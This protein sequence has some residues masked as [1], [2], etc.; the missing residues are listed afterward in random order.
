[1]GRGGRGMPEGEERNDPS[2]EALFREAEESVDRIQKERQ[3][4]E[5]GAGA[6]DAEA[7][8]LQAELDRV[9][10]MLEKVEAVRKETNEKWLK[11]TAE[12]QKAEAEKKDFS[13]KALRALAELENF[14]KRVAKER[15]D[16]QKYAPEGLAKEILGVADNLE[17]A[18]D[19]AQAQP[20]QDP[21]LVK[22]AEGVRM[23]RTQLMQAL[24]RFEIKPFES[25]GQPFDPAKHQAMSHLDTRDAPPGTVMSEMQKGY[26]LHDRLLRPAFVV[27]SREPLGSEG[28]GEAPEG[29]NGAMPGGDGGAGEPPS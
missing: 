23:T 10:G 24:A 2:V 27:V 20:S 8:R 16:A 5:A 7:A 14:R 19:A 22:L 17:R 1:M 6:Q 25:V 4:G 12:T 15:A 26:L 18:L 29:G 11:A 21:V 3:G 9:K 28:G 13:D